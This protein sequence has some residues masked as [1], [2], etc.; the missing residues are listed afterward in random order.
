MNSWQVLKLD[1]FIC[2][3]NNSPE[4]YVFIGIFKILLC[5]YWKVPEMYLKV[6][7]K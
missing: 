5:Y 2:L 6:F 3:E 7:K 4:I 1:N